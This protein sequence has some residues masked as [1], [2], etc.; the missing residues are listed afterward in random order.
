VD[1]ID[2]SCD[3]MSMM[4]DVV[5]YKAKQIWPCMMVLNDWNVEKEVK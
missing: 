3:R 1:D 2:T 5:E 4:T